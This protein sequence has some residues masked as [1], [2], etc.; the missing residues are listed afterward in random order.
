MIYSGRACAEVDGRTV[1]TTAT[2]YRMMF[3]PTKKKVYP[4]FPMSH[5]MDLP[6]T[7]KQIEAFKAALYEHFICF[8]PADVGWFH[9]GD[10]AGLRGSCTGAAAV[11]S[12]S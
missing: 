8:D 6:D 3:E 5:V 9:G 12:R 2:L 10:F 7:L 11:A 4:S 1:A